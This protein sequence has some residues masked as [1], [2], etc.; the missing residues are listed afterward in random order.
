M[1]NNVDRKNL[2]IIDAAEFRALLDAAA[3]GIVAIDRDGRIFEFN[4]AAQRLFRYSAA[5]I[6][7]KNVRELM[8]EPDRS[9]HDSYIKR[10]LETGENRIIGIGREVSGQRS[11]GSTF[12]IH[13]SVGNAGDR[14]VGII[15]DLSAE[16][17]AEEEG[18]KLQDRL[19][20]VDRFSLMG[21]MAAGLAHEINQPLSAI[22]TYAQA[23]KRMM[24]HEPVDIET[25]E[26]LCSKISDQALRAGQIIQSLRSFVSKQETRKDRLDINEVVE[27][28]MGLIKADARAEGIRI[29]IEY[30]TDV[31]TVKG[32]EVQLQQVLLNLTRNAVD[33]MQDGLRKESGISVRTSKSDDNQTVDVAVSDHGHGVSQQLVDSIFNPFVTTKREGLGVGLAVSRT[34]IQAHGGDLYYMPKPEGGSVFGFSLPIAQEK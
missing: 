25:L 16:K 33:A 14:F 4:P 23:G 3:D 24:G 31:P 29:S 11:D 34:I 17:A 2:A 19:S 5:D 26:E 32:D 10:H 9:S 30:A 20:E 15:R 12:P 1:P 7:G 22:S 28:V 18:R 27:N 21:E 8:P 6:I 13:L